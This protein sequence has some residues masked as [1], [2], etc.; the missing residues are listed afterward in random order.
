VP[1]LFP[2]S[3]LRE[4]YADHYAFA[5]RYVELVNAKFGTRLFVNPS[6]LFI[7]VKSTYDDIERYKLYHIENPTETKSNSVKRVAYLTK[8]IVKSRPIQYSPDHDLKNVTPYIANAGFALALAR[9]HIA[10]EIKKEFFFTLAKET[11]MIYDL[12]YR[13]MTGDGL[14]AL[15]QGF[16]D[17][18]L[19][20]LPFE[21]LVEKD[22]SDPPDRP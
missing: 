16:Y 4:H 12:S 6:A 8:W 5:R 20:N 14:L 9:A 21:R 1:R 13:E 11:E 2:L 18:L 3:L 7:A 17:L 15:Y 19:N 22:F 10:A